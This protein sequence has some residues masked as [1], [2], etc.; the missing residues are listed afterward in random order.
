MVYSIGGFNYMPLVERQCIENGRNWC[1]KHMKS[2]HQKTMLLHIVHGESMM[3]VCR[4]DIF[5]HFAIFYVF[6]LHI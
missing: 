5:L 2:V 1:Y 6:F 4:V 3:L